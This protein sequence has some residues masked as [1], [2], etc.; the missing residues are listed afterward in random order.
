M[1]TFCELDDYHVLA[2]TV[3]KSQSL[4]TINANL[5]HANLCKCVKLFMHCGMP[6]VLHLCHYSSA[7]R[8][9]KEQVMHDKCCL[10]TANANLQDSCMRA[11]RGVLAG[12]YVQVRGMLRRLPAGADKAPH[13]AA[14]AAQAQAL[15]RAAAAHRVQAV[16][17]PEPPQYAALQAR[18]QRALLRDS[19]PGSQTNQHGCC[20]EVQTSKAFMQT[21]GL[22]LHRNQTVGEGHAW[23][24][25][26]DW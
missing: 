14:L 1:D 5:F 17:R 8:L 19:A 13:I 15:A 25:M 21:A 24:A 22:C 26:H 10:R 7:H 9:D 23:R 4:W 3:I 12:I 18:S 2:M 16:P 20:L 6:F 11:A